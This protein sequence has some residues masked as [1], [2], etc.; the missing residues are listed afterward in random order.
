[1]I[2]AAVLESGSTFHGR[3]LRSLKVSLTLVGRLRGAGRRVDALR[4]GSSEP[5]SLADAR[6]KVPPGAGQRVD[7]LWRVS[8]EARSGPEAREMVSRGWKAGRCFV[9]GFFGAWRRL[10]SSWEGFAGLEGGSTLCGRVL[11]SLEALLTL[12]RRFHGAGKR[13][14]VSWKG[15][16]EPGRGSDAR[17]KVPPGA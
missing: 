13:V 11:R 1:L 5:R 7:D 6:E 12:V 15:S 14:D 2:V 3:V 17:R 16:S 10:G 4:K 8:S 9:E